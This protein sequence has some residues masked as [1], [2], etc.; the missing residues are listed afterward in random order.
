MASFEGATWDNESSDGA[1]GAPSKDTRTSVAPMSDLIQT[2][3]TDGVARITLNRPQAINALNLEMLQAMVHVLTEYVRR[4]KHDGEADLPPVTA[5]EFAGAGER[6]FCS[7]ADVRQLAA[8]IDAGQPW[9]G[10]LELEYALDGLVAS[11]PM[12]TTAHMT[13]I[14]MG[15]GLGIASKASTRIVDASTV[16]AMPET[17]IGLFPDAGVMYQL[18]RGG[19]VGT[20]VALTSS[21]FG[22]GDA[23]AL[24]LADVSASGDLP[25]PLADAAADWIDECYAGDDVVEIARRLEAH[26]HPDARAAAVDLRAR[27]PFAVH[28]A[29]RALRRAESLDPHEVLAQDLRIAEG[30]V[31][32]DFTEGVR[33]LLVDKDNQPRWRHAGLEDVPSSLVDEVFAY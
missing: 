18:S 8:T 7:G 4:Q 13:G 9:L 6:G 3:V 1:R 16:L 14:T 27:S 28:V 5:V 17:R 22:G 20:H 25:T 30:M 19:G 29:L 24:G 32:V 31:P 26:A 2:S 23:I 15:G 10:F 21:T 33:A 12:P 11:Y